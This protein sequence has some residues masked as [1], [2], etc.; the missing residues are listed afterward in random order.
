MLRIRAQTG[1]L[2]AVVDHGAAALSLVRNLVTIRG[3]AHGGDRR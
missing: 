2:T 1:V 3:I